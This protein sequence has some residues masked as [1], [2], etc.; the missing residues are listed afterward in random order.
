MQSAHCATRTFGLRLAAFSADPSLPRIDIKSMCYHNY[1]M[2]RTQIQLPDELYRLARQTA[3][4][5]EISLAELVRRGLEYIIAVSPAP[6]SEKRVWRLPT[7][8]L[9]GGDPFA[10]PEWRAR[11]HTERLRVA[12]RGSAY[13]ERG[14]RK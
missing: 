14:S 11:L 6:V 3:E 5:K 4:R 10:D 9:G 2:I 13:G 8:A 7:V 12:E 1:T